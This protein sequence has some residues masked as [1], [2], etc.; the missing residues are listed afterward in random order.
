MEKINNQKETDDTEKIISKRVLIKAIIASII[1]LIISIFS[2]IGIGYIAKADAENQYNKCLNNPPDISYA[3]EDLK[4]LFV[5][6][7]VEVLKRE[8]EED[9]CYYIVK[10]NGLYFKVAYCISDKC[11][12]FP[13]IKEW[14]FSRCVQISE[15]ELNEQISQ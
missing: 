8:Q 12:E 6:T 7:N 9:I 3:E 1:V 13:G 15:D 11:D 5:T 14:K 2:I 4:Y 10:A